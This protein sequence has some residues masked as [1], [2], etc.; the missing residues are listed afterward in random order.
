MRL[1]LFL[2]DER[3]AAFLLSIESHPVI[4]VVG[5]T[6]GIY[7][8]FVRRKANVCC[9]VQNLSTWDAHAQNNNACIQLDIASRS[10]LPDKF[11]LKPAH[12][13]TLYSWRAKP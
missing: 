5:E 3:L 13:K 2:N 10:V 12:D 8:F 9:T 1:H 6:H 11:F 4:K 7:G